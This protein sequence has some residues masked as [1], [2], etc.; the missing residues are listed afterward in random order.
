[1][2]AKRSPSE[3]VL[4]KRA[5]SERDVLGFIT[6]CVLIDIGSVCAGEILGSMC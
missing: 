2:G 6:I 4:G 3:G 5:H 1:M